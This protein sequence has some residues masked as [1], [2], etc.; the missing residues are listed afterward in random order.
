MVEAVEQV[1]LTQYKD[2]VDL[3]QPQEQPQQVPLIHQLEPQ[4]VKV[5]MLT[6]TVFKVVGPVEAAEAVWVELSF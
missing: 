1:G 2:K 5:V 6:Q 4:V 3:M